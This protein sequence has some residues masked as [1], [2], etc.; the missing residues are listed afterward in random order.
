MTFIN[1]G[2]VDKN[3]FAIIIGC[4]ACFLNRLLNQYKGTILFQNKI[5]TSI[6]IVIPRILTVF[7]LI[8]IKIRSRSRKKT[9]NKN[10][11]NSLIKKNELIVRGKWAYI[12]LSAI[13]FSIQNIFL[14]FT[15]EIK[16]NA[17]I[18][19]ILLASIIY[20]LIFRNKLYKHHYI[21]IIFILILGIT[22]D[23][24]TE[25][26]QN[27]ITNYFFLFKYLK[28]IFFSLYNVMAKYVMDKKYVSVYEF[29]F[30]IGAI[31]LILSGIFMVLD[32]FFLKFDNLEKYFNNF[33]IKEL[34]VMLG[35]I[36]SQFVLNIAYLFTIKIYSPC[37]VFIIF[38]FGQLAYYT[39]FIEDYLVST[40][41]IICLIFILFLSLIFCEIV[42]LNFLGL[43]YNTKKNIAIRAKMEE[44]FYN[45]KN[46]IIDEDIEER[47]ENDEYLITL[48]EEKSSKYSETNSSFT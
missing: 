1:L 7:P 14:V 3:I 6:Y 47:I 32:Y 33:D 27:E 12:M 8:F 44:D 34:L 36:I 30:Y 39:T 42:E 18:C 17:W 43:S 40:S 31:N 15:F 13:I 37:H 25:N 46:E 48:K 21:T 38:V 9:I 29:S 26:I 20:Y 19:Y 41:V 22:I 10:I 28:E 23:L 16:T 35:V 2:Q 24:I 5:L 4:V 45:N 11:I